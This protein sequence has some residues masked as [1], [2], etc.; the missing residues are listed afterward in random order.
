MVAFE[1]D[2]CDREDRDYGL[3]VQREKHPFM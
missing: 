3:A 1:K 2:Y